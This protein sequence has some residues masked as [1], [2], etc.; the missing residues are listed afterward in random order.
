MYVVEV[1]T[2]QGETKYLS[3]GKAVR[4]ENATHYYHPS[5]AKRAADS[6]RAKL[7]DLPTE[8]KVIRS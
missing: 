6:W 2:P 8:A 7:K 5:G 1:L 4:R 3:R